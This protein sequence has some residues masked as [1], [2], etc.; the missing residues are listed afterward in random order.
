MLF[1]KDNLSPTYELRIGRPGSSYAFEIAEKV[2]LPKKVLAYAK[3]KTGKNEK[4]VDELLIDLQR[5]K[6]EVEEHLS[7]I[8]KK[9]KNLDHLIKSYEDMS[10]DYEYRRKKLKLDI[11]ESE[12]QQT[13][14]ENHELEKLI[15]EIRE[16]QNLEKAKELAA[17]RRAERERL[18][19]VVDEI[20][21]E[22]HFQTITR[23]DVERG[24]IKKGD[25]VKAIKGGAQGTVES[26]HKTKAT[27]IMGD[28]RIEFKISDLQHAN[29]QLN[30]IS[31]PRV[32]MDFISQSAQ[33]ES[34]IDLRGMKM[35]DAMITL[36]NFID[37]A[38]NRSHQSAVYKVF[39][40][41]HCVKHFH[42]TKV[43]I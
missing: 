7:E 26:I 24:P 21:T 9:Q 30:I 3:H 2:G 13:S 11:K 12:L 14:R 5:E 35:F 42:S 8:L 25:L 31:A 18:V 22:L 37:R 16:K 15:R 23:K 28:L 1:D 33:F 10:K 17:E 27:V 34:N 20:N 41:D 29:E 36:E 38:L 4:A 19:E 43:Y 39:E 40:R 32:R 6:Q